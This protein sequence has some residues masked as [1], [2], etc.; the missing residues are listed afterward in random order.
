MSLWQEDRVVS[1]PPF[2]FPEG[3]LPSLLPLHL[4]FQA[5]C[6]RS[7][8]TV[9]PFTFQPRP[10]D[11]T[12]LNP[13]DP[14]LIHSAVQGTTCDKSKLWTRPLVPSSL[15]PSSCLPVPREGPP[16][17]TCFS[18]P[19]LSWVSRQLLGPGPH[20]SATGTSLPIP[21]PCS[22]PFH[23]LPELPSLLPSL[24][25]LAP[26]QGLLQLR[27]PP[28]Q[29]ASPLLSGQV[30]LFGHGYPSRSKAWGQDQRSLLTTVP[31]STVKVC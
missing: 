3:T 8:S 1:D 10:P 22:H 11:S 16:H 2:P 24:P 9:T 5:R 28:C 14:Q 6:S 7:Q 25:C 29:G 27:P 30:W 19:P 17:R 26:T 18:R 21:R 31:R 23:S 15:V 20:R 4:P 13:A 12:P